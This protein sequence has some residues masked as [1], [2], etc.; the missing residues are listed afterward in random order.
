MPATHFNY[1]QM[2]TV[3]C[4]RVLFVCVRLFISE[5]TIKAS[6]RAARGIML[7]KK[8]SKLLKDEGNRNFHLFIA[9]SCSRGISMQCGVLNRLKHKE[10][11][12]VGC[13][14]SA[15]HTCRRQN[16]RV[17]RSR[18]VSNPRWFDNR[19]RLKSPK[20]FGVTAT[21]GSSA[22]GGS[23]MSDKQQN[24]VTKGARS[25]PVETALHLVLNAAFYLL[26]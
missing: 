9:H 17:D 18:A 4:A 14:F 22:D 5:R 24:A 16:Q 21:S 15:L 7:I 12:L 25:L 10:N 19:P 1:P 11:A 2:M 3:T 8:C 23:H 13:M 26:T 6:G 20:F